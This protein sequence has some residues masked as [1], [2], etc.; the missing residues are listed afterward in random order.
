MGKP[1]ATARPGLRSLSHSFT[2]DFVMGCALAVDARKLMAGLPQRFAR[3][4]LRMHPTKPALIAFRQPEAHQGADTGNGT[5]DLLGLPHYGTQSRRGCWVINR[6][7]A[8]KRL[9]R[10]KQSLGRWCRPNRHAPFKD[11]DQ[12][13]CQK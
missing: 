13:L 1:A 7:T 3:V 10:P 11:Q 5:F 8:R 4:G 2:L 12:R 9:C 6:R